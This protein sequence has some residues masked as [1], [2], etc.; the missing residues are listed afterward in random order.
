MRVQR[1][2]LLPATLAAASLVTLA[3]CNRAQ[4]DRTAG[5]KVDSAVAKVEQ[6]TDQAAAEVKKDLESAKAAVG[7]AVDATANKVKDATITT[8]IKAELTKDASLSALKINVDTS[9][10]QVSLRGTAPSAAAREQA[11]KLAQ[12]VQ[13]VVSVDNQLQVSSN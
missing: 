8:S 2:P 5:Q 9:A 7:Q 13:G 11:T 12:G 6:K 4:D 1:F 10:G 3:A